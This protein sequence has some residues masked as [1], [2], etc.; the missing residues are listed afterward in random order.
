LLEVAKL[1]SIEPVGPNWVSDAEPPRLT[2]AGQSDRSFPQ[3]ISLA[4]EGLRRTQQ[5]RRTGR[6]LLDTSNPARLT[7]AEF[8]ICVLFSEGWT[9]P[10]LCRQLMISPSTLRAHLRSILAKTGLAT[11]A[12][13]LTCL[14]GPV[15]DS[16]QMSGRADCR[17]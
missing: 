9:M 3:M 15:E 6:S 5:W 17:P 13:L 4:E 8:R 12:E 1:N 7:R 16:L 14:P 11:L 10:D 2:P